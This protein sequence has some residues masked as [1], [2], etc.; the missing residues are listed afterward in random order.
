MSDSKD[1]EKTQEPTGTPAPVVT[2]PT[3]APVAQAPV[4]AD[5]TVESKNV[6]A[7]IRMRKADKANKQKIAE[8]EAKLAAAPVVP[9]VETPAP[10]Q[11][12]AKVTPAP[13]PVAETV[14]SEEA[15][16]Q[17][18][19]KDADVIAVPGG[20]IDIMDLVDSDPKLSRLNEIDH[21]LAFTEA[22]KLW[23]SKLGIGATPPTPVPSKISGGISKDTTDLGELFKAVDQAKP[24]SKAYR[25]AV[26]KVNEAMAKGR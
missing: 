10:T 22:K 3:Q 25:E 14:V 4:P 19:A 26:K 15:A 13:A 5:S 9:A 21:R 7:F 17:E 23:A 18:I 2:E 1:A 16:I 20:I 12:V 8:L 24:G 6:S 11:T